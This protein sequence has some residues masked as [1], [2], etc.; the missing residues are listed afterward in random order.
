MLIAGILREKTFH[1]YDLMADVVW[2]HVCYDGDGDD[3]DVGN[4]E[5]WFAVHDSMTHLKL[6][7]LQPPHEQPQQEM[8]PLDLDVV[9]DDCA[10]VKNHLLQH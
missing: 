4:G 9:G 6:A 5:N 2:V 8:L 1:T 3:D 10:S 7:V